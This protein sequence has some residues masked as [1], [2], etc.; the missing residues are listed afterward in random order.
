MARPV[1]CGF[2]LGVTLTMQRGAVQD[3]S[4]RLARRSRLPLRQSRGR[5]AVGAQTPGTPAGERWRRSRARRPHD[6]RGG[7]PGVDASSHPT[8]PPPIRIAR[9][10]RPA[11]DRASTGARWRSRRLNCCG[12]G[13]LSGDASPRHGVAWRRTGV[14]PRRGP[15]PA[16]TGVRLGLRLSGPPLQAGRTA[17]TA[18]GPFS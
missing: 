13:R 12:R 15:P 2:G 3:L 9:L 16:V 6:R 14:T 7:R 18:D 1:P 8:G 11:G 10:P 4:P 17:Q 5:S